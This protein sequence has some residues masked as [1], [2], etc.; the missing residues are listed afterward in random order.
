VR[1]RITVGSAATVVL[2]A[3]VRQDGVANPDQVAG[4]SD[5]TASYTSSVFAWQRDSLSFSGAY[6]RCTTNCTMLVVEPVTRTP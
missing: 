3:R 1:E 5:P 2:Y 4:A 6:G